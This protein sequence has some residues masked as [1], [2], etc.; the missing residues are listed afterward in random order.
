MP[1]TDPYH[2]LASA[3]GGVTGFASQTFTNAAVSGVDMVVYYSRNQHDGMTG[4]VL[5]GPDLYGPPSCTFPTCN[6]VNPDRLVTGEWALRVTRDYTDARTPVTVVL[7][8]SA[9]VYLYEFIVGSLSE[10]SGSYEHAIVRGFS[11]ADATGPVVKASGLINISNL[12][13]GSTLINGFWDP[14]GPTTSNGLAN[15]AVEPSLIDS[16]ADGVYENI[17]DGTDD[18]V[19][20]LYGA[21]LQTSDPTTSHYGR[22]KWVYGDAPVRSIAISYFPTSTANGT[23]FDDTTY[24]EQ[25]I[26]AIFAAVAFSEEA[27]TAVTLQ[28]INA[29]AATNTFLII[30]MTLVLLLI[31]ASRFYY[32]QRQHKQTL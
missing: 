8:F 15:L 25:W 23:P 11:S 22:A 4:D 24:T 17:G 2:G 16:N 12:T 18:G 21:G 10:V 28:N 19:Y 7:S 30:I 14:T 5:E 32:K 20:H 6:D 1:H 27:P 26:S 13:D 29:T 31:G 9:P 3:T